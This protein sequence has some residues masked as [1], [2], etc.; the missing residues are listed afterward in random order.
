MGKEE[1]ELNGGFSFEISL[2]VL[3]HL[4]RNLY[5]SFVTV[6]GEAISNSWDADAGNVWITIDRDSDSF[7]IKDDGVGMSAGDFQDKFLRIGYSKRKEGQ[8]SGKGRPFIGRKG[9][10]KLALLSCAEKITVIS[11]VKGGEYVGGTIDNSDLDDAIKKDLEPSDYNLGGYDMGLFKGL[12]DDHDQ[13]TIIHFRNVKEGIRNRLDYLKEVVAMYFRFS[14]IDSSFSL[15]INGDRISIK[16]LEK[17]SDKTQFLWVINGFKDPLFDQMGSLVKKGRIKMPGNVK[18]FIASVEKPSHRKIRSTDEKITVDLFVNGRLRERDLLKHMPTEGIFESYLYG[19]VHVDGLDDGTDRFTTSREGIVTNDPKFKVFL[20]DLKAR[21][22]GLS[23]DW[24][25]WR[26]ENKDEG[27]PENKRKDRKERASKSLYDEVSKEY[28]NSEGMNGPENK[29]RLKEWIDGLEADGTFNTKSY[30]ECFLSENLLRKFIQENGKEI[31]PESKR[32]IEHLKERE[33]QNKEKGNVR[34]SIR[35][36][37][38]DL[39]YLDMNHLSAIIDRDRKRS[40]S[41]L[42]RDAKPYRPIRDAIMHTSIITKEAKDMLSSIFD[43][44]KGRINE[45]LS[46]GRN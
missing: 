46:A 24:D 16:H 22:S 13:G 14:L 15:V 25:D 28:E 45:L 34:I 19:Q 38:D 5:R 43:N 3:N 26:R 2:S 10:G 1:T 31:T 29:R 8:V 39:A 35:K 18:G 6:L 33:R 21:L 20:A 42:V 40:D 12:T 11:K 30:I 44:I 36:A 17:I 4:G 41:G 9:I 37:D 7:Y 23:D 27:D 32:E